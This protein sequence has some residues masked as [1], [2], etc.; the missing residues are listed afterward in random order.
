MCALAEL[1]QACA[2]R[3]QMRFSR[4]PQGC[5][6]SDRLSSY[7]QWPLSLEAA[8]ANETRRGLEVIAS[9]ETVAGAARFTRGDGRH[10][11]PAPA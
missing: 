10:G 7:E 2:S 5:M 11:N 3:K 6:R 8:M 4:L 1:N 9:G